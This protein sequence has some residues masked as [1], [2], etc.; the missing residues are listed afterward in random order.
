MNIM[1]KRSVISPVMLSLFILAFLVAP[2]AAAG[3]LITNGDPITSTDGSTSPVITIEGEQIDINGTITIDVSGLNWYVST[4][5]FSTENVVIHDSAAA[6]TWTGAVAG[7]DTGT[8]LTLTSTG[9]N[10]SAGENVTVTFT[11]AVNPWVDNPSGSDWGIPL[12]ATRTD[13][14]QTGDFTIVITS[15]PPAGLSIADGLPITATD[16]STSPV[17]TITDSPIAQNGTITISVANVHQ[18]VVGYSFTT[19]NVVVTSFPDAEKWTA[20]VNGNILTLT[21]SGGATE[22]GETVTVTFTGSSGKPWF[23]DMA[24]TVTLTAKRTDGKGQDYFDFGINTPPPVP[25]II[26]EGSKITAPNGATSPVIAI[27]G[28]NITRNGT[29]VIDVSGLNG[30][31]PG[32]LTN[33]NVEIHRSAAAANWTRTITRDSSGTYLTLTSAGGPTVAGDNV[34]VTF[35]GATHPWTAN[36]EGEKTVSLVATRTDGAGEG[37]FDFV[38]ETTPP[39]GFF[40]VANFTASPTADIAPLTTK[41]ID[42]SSGNPVSWYWDFGDGETSRSK[43]PSHTYTDIGTYTVSLTAANEYGAD[44]KTQ[45][46]TVLNGAIREAHTTIAGLTIANCEGRQTVTVDT[47]VLTAALIPNNS[48]LELQPPAGSGFAAITIFAKNGFSQNGTRIVGKPTGVR[49]VTEEIAP[50]SGFS[51]AIGKNASFTYSIEL[52]SYPCNAKLSTK[53]WEGV[54]PRYDT[55]FHRIASANGAFPLGTAY[56]AKVTSTNFPPDARVQLH[57]SVNTITF[58]E[59]LGDA[60]GRMYIWRIADDEKS[61]QI[62]P[63]SHLYS[64]PVNSLDY[65]EAD[66]PRG[67]STFGISSLT[68]NNNPFQLITFTLISIIKSEGGSGGKVTPS[69]VI[70]PAMTPGATPVPPDPGCTVPIYA[71]TDGV[72]T[73]DTMLQSTDGFATLSLGQGIVAATSRGKPLP[74]V[75]IRRIPSDNLPG[76]SPA[77]ELSF[78]G[79]AYD[80]QPDGATFSPSIPLSFTIPQAQWGAEYVIQ[81]YDNKSGTWQALLSRYNPQTGIITAD[82][83]HFCCFA[84]FAKATTPTPNEQ[85]VVKDDLGPLTQPAISTNLGMIVWGFTMLQKNPLVL[86]LIIAVIAFIT[87]FGWWRQR[88]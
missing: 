20:A 77:A 67:L 39:H 84:L 47:S 25:L 42:T 62:L 13:T 79:M 24:T 14:G 53:I 56:T 2:V 4:Y 23:S 44:T 70:S 19:D 18:Y 7:N 29:I 5:P 68:G 64:D 82:I 49:L 16:G 86:I 66:S 58:N 88:L 11:G 52:P 1:T 32:G 83:S 63:T 30:V 37:T 3:L 50:S 27:T 74:S 34:T 78:A 46:I 61:G 45:D 43:N 69:V 80:I 21:S 75:S 55:L 33:A 71:N 48:V 17:I 35:T 31:V 60:T 8:F 54:I 6:A 85:E 22:I 65:Y 41:F 38:I 12:T 73:Q 57:M 87:Y 15:P 81:G 51:T 72:V 9:G 36:T 40:V 26:S 59:F 28:S 10:T 76:G